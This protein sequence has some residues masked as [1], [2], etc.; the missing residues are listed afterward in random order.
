MY[1][2]QFRAQIVA[3]VGT[4]PYSPFL[5]PGDHFWQS[6]EEN[7][8]QKIFRRDSPYDLKKNKSEIDI[9]TRISHL[10]KRTVP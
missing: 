9:C 6:Y 1:R 10:A 4:N 2:P 7:Q 5:G 8:A 3:G